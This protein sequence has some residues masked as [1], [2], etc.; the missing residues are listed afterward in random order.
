MLPK[1]TAAQSL[2][3]TATRPFALAPTRSVVPGTRGSLPRNDIFQLM[4]DG[5][6]Q[7]A[8]VSHVA[9]ARNTQAGERDEY[10][11]MSGYSGH[12]KTLKSLLQA[13]PDKIQSDRLFRILNSL[14]VDVVG[15]ANKGNHQFDCAEPHAVA[16]L[17]LMDVPLENIKITSIKLA[18]GPNKGES[19]TPCRNC[20]QWLEAS[21]GGYVIKKGMLDKSWRDSYRIGLGRVSGK[22]LKAQLTQNL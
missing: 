19:R 10:A 21:V 11:V 6:D 2:G 17:A 5:D 13:R 16:N 9:E 15:G 12:G 1:M 8:F 22:A 18:D 3:P 20:S 4:E 7:P 14:V